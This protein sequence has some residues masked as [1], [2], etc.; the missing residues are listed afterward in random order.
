MSFSLSM[1]ASISRFAQS[2]A[3]SHTILKVTLLALSLARSFALLDMLAM[4][5]LHMLVHLLELARAHTLYGSAG[6]AM[7]ANLLLFC[8]IVPAYVCACM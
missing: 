1:S 3:L 7:L 8:T 2:P 6:G 4:T 5:R